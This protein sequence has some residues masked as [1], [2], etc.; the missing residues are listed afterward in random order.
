MVKKY[1][2]IDQKHNPEAIKEFFLN[3]DKNIEKKKNVKIKVRGRIGRK[4]LDSDS[5]DDYTDIYK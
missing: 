1:S 4:H 5:E 3:D 2:G